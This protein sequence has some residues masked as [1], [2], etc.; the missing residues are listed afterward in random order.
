[1]TEGDKPSS[2]IAVYNDTAILG[3]EK[4]FVNLIDLVTLQTKKFKV[5]DRKIVTCQI[6]KDY[7]FVVCSN[8]N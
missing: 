8:D 7:L 5:G 2:N 1:V 3:D 4:G 6:F